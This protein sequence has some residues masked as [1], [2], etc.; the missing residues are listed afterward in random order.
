MTGI[1]SSS[2]I[3]ASCLTWSAVMN[4]TSS[5]STAVTGRFACSAATMAPMASSFLKGVASASR[6]RRDLTLPIPKRSSIRLV[7]SSTW[8]PFSM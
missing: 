7:N 8:P 2:T 5:M 4:C 1:F 6:P 3:Q